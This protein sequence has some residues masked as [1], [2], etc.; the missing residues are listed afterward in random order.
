MT[1]IIY[2]TLDKTMSAQITMHYQLL[3]HSLLLM[4][5]TDDL[6]VGAFRC[7]VDHIKSGG[8]MRGQA[9]KDTVKILLLCPPEMRLTVRQNAKRM[10][11]SAKNEIGYSKE[12]L[13]TLRAINKC[14]I[15]FL[16]DLEPLRMKVRMLRQE[17]KR[18]GLLSAMN[19]IDDESFKI[20]LGVEY[21]SA[22]SFADHFAKSL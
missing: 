19:P 21:I 22:E 14:A 13:Q 16:N 6:T 5:W 4:T 9:L 20:L 12:S 7:M 17:K 10:E 15:G 1:N 3:T 18:F 8:E 2:E 11:L